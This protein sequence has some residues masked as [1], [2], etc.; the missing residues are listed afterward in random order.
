M[1]GK[2]REFAN[3]LIW[4]SAIIGGIAIIFFVLSAGLMNHANVWLAVFFL[5]PLVVV[6]ALIG[7]LVGMAIRKSGRPFQ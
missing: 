3:W 7:I 4:N 6:I 1:A 5:S 2:K